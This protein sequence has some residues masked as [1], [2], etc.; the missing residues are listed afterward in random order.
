MSGRK[1]LLL[2]NGGHI[3][4]PGN[5]ELI[6]DIFIKQAGLDVEVSHDPAE[7][8]RERLETADLLLDY[9]GDPKVLA[10]DAQLEAV[11]ATV[12]GGKPYL[13]LHAASLPF[14]DL[15]GLH[16]LVEGEGQRPLSY[17]KTYGQGTIVY[18]ALGHGATALANPN[19]QRM[20]VQAAEW[21]RLGAA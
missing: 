4:L 21:L 12:E 15:S 19:L 20:Y 6:E 17:V 13:G 9:S 16:L 2:T 5:R 1:A 7:L 11:M 3:N 10:T 8:T 18:M 14:R